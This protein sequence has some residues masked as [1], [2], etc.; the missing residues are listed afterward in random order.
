MAPD[1]ADPRSRKNRIRPR[2]YHG[3]LRW[4]CSGSRNRWSAAPT[5]L[6]QTKQAEYQNRTPNPAAPSGL[7]LFF[8]TNRTRPGNPCAP[9]LCTLNFIFG[10]QLYQT[11][12]M[13]NFQRKRA[14]A[15]SSARLGG[16]TPVS[17][18]VKP[19]SD[20]QTSFGRFQ[21]RLDTSTGKPNSKKIQKNDTDI[22]E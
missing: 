21:L 13:E 3:P 8:R 10:I 15:C 9:G 11:C 16:S 7:V 6:G 2:F 22:D 20:R 12:S 18:E 19:A 1:P 14:S 5:V 4:F 17:K